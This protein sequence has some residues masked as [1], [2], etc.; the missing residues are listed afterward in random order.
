MEYRN[1]N[2]IAMPKKRWRKHLHDGASVSLVPPPPDEQ[3]LKT[4]RSFGIAIPAGHCGGFA[5]AQYA[6]LPMTDL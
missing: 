5:S 4:M 3:N 6:L 2:N 1:D